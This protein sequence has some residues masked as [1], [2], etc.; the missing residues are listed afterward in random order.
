M[1]EFFTAK[2][3]ARAAKQPSGHD[4]PVAIWEAL[5]GQISVLRSA[6]SH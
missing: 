5:R 4:C 1:P 2:L 6:S 3:D